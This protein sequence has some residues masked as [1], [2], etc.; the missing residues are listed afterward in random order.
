MNKALIIP[1]LLLLQGCTTPPAPY[2]EIGAGYKTKADWHL[3]PEHAGGRNPTAH[4]ELGLEFDNQFSCAYNH[5][6]HYR[7]GG[8]F[9]H[10]P[11]T[12]KDEILCSKRW[13]GKKH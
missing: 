8:P 12:Y 4:I 5:W 13:G 3:Q 1:L 9:N 7:D 2:F 6:S 11:E 10:H